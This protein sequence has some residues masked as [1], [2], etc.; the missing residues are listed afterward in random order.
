[1]PAPRRI[2]LNQ[3]IFLWVLYNLIKVLSD[4]DS[5]IPVKWLDWDLCGFVDWSE[6]PLLLVRH[7]LAD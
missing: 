3:N 1:M 5:D 7:K 4:K 2:D 6:K